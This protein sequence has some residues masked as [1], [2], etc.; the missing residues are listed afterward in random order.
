MYTID[1]VFL[2][3]FQYIREWFVLFTSRHN[4]WQISLKHLHWDPI[5]TIGKSRNQSILQLLSW[6]F[7]NFVDILHVVFDKNMIMYFINLQPSFKKWKL[8]ECFPYHFGHR[9]HM[10]W[11][12]KKKKIYRFYG[13]T[14]ALVICCGFCVDLGEL[15]SSFACAQEWDHTSIKQK[16]NGHLVWKK[17]FFFGFRYVLKAYAL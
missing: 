13:N 3:I 10:Y 8:Q 4:L 17:V 14:L 7:M 1:I 12:F 16:I 6:S 15:T 9:I 11:N 5:N 2:H